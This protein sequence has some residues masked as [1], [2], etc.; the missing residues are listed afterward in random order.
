MTLVNAFM[1]INK[2]ILITCALL[3]CLLITGC[4]SAQ[5]SSTMIYPRKPA[6]T[7]GRKAGAAMLLYEQAEKDLD[8]ND[9]VIV[10]PPKENPNTSEK[11]E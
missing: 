5:H 8:V 6:E 2:I 1:H 7:D 11:T 9:S 4:G 10:T 3:A